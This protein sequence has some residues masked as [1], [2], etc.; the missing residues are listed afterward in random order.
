MKNRGL[1]EYIFPISDRSRRLG[2]VH[3][4]KLQRFNHWFSQ[5]I[6]I[7]LLQLVLTVP[8]FFPQRIQPELH[9]SERLGSVW[10]SRKPL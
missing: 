8:I 1:I 6:S 10:A 7:V 4:S 5:V 9:D 3:L 2:E